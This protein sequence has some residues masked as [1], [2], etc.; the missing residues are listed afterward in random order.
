MAL[1][2]D[3]SFPVLKTLLKTKIFILHGGANTMKKLE[4]HDYVSKGQSRKFDKLLKKVMAFM[5]KS[6]VSYGSIVFMD[7]DYVN[8]Q[9]ADKTDY[10]T[11]T[12]CD[13]S[14]N[15]LYDVSVW[16]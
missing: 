7:K 6:G 13:K 16:R 5:Q 10:C 12:I 14:N 2:N 9:A 3:I 11:I 15:T 4:L 8:R 1:G